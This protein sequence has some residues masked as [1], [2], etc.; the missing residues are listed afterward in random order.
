MAAVSQAQKSSEAASLVFVEGSFEEL[1]LEMADFLRIADEVKPLVETKATEEVLAKLV[2]A[3][4]SLTSVPENNFTAAAN[5]MIYLVFQSADPKK[6]LPALCSSFSKP[7]AN[8]INGVSLSLNALTTIFNLLPSSNPVRFRVLLEILK[9]LKQG[10]MWESLRPYLEFLPAWIQEWDLSRDQQ[11]QVYEET[12]EVAKEAGHDGES[13]QYVLKALRTF[14]PD[15]TEDLSSEPAQRLAL[16]AVKAALLSNTHFLFQELRSIPAV[17]ALSDSHPAYAQLL[18]IFAEQDLEDYNDFNDEHNGFLESEG[19]DAN[20]LHRKMRLL[21]FASLAAATPNREIPY[22]AIVK[23]LQI[24][25]DEVELWT[26]DAIRVGLVEGKLSQQKSVFLVH[27]VTFRVFS[28]RQ[29]RELSTR[30]DQWKTTLRSVLDNLLQARTDLKVQQE[31][32][33]QEL[34]NKLAAAAANNADNEKGN[35]KGG[36]GG[37][38][39]HNNTNNN[40]R[41]HKPRGGRDHK[42]PREPKERNENDD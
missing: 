38:R 24:P 37:D 28:I 6:H 18:E 40:N 15:S 22:A 42:Q 29:W 3:S 14:N 36:R 30:V 7:V 13:F 12:S 27:K 34:E 31:R 11:R 1:A 17:Q 26:I 2:K 32:E 35:S 10:G 9:Y 20:V 4:S 16:A 33:A 8:S 25:D 39:R 41:D 21:S 5:L 19:L 23:A